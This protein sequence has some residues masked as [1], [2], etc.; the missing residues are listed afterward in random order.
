M[1]Y[2]KYFIAKI[3]YRNK[4]TNKIQTQF[5]KIKNQ[6]TSLIRKNKEE[7]YKNYFYKHDKNLK[8][9]GMALGK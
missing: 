3:R 1:D 9:Y 6:I 4:L 7:Y 5:N 8:R 2:P